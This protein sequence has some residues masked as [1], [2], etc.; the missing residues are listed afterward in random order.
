MHH[1]PLSLYIHWP[2]C[3][4]KCPYCD[5]N[6]HVR[7]SIE[8]D[9]WKTALLKEMDYW[10]SQTGP[11]PLNSIFFGG[12][13]PSLMSPQT[14]E[15]LIDKALQL[16]PRDGMP[17]ITLEA[18]PNSIDLEKFKAF[19][20][21]GIN[22]VSIGIQSLDPDVLKFLG[23]THSKDEALK[24][25][26]V[27]QRTFDRYSFDLIY[28]RPEQ[29]WK[30]WEKELNN[31][32][33][34]VNGHISLYQLTIEPQTA[35]YNAYARGDW[36]L[37]SEE[38]QADLYLQT[39]ALLADQ[40]LDAYEISNY[41]QKG[42][43]CR[44]NLAYW[45]YEDYIP[46]GPGAHGRLTLDNKVALRNLKAPETW[47]KTVADKGHGLQESLTLTKDEQF[48]EALL[49]GLR[50][51]DGIFKETLSTLNR[52]RFT[53]ITPLLEDFINQGVLLASPTHIKVAPQ[54]RLVLN[55]IV[56][57]LNRI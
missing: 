30:A 33:V 28:A 37:P 43:E 34:L 4:S 53:A 45:R 40:G 44:H 11:R 15:A 52:E 50:L 39:N 36:Q 9:Q 47:L 49:M 48:T 57:R 32:L 7:E 42:Q 46:I 25:I 41:A 6:S 27:A 22:R 54:S 51:K 35:F 19:R 12:G 21:A 2:F 8:E 16:W 17:E 55:Y 13:T 26:D 5:F 31:A 29:T 38:E 3:L 23:R 56:D 10:G 18:N 1:K 20:Q 24:A 14:V